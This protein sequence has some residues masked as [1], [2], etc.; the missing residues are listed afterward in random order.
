MTGACRGGLIPRRVLDGRS[1][2]RRMLDEEALNSRRGGLNP[3][4]VLDG[5]PQPRRVL[6]WAVSLKTDARRGGTQFQ[7]GRPQSKRV[8]DRLVLQARRCILNLDDYQAGR[9]QIYRRGGLRST[10]MLDREVFRARRAGLICIRGSFTPHG[11]ATE[12]HFES[13]GKTSKPDGAVSF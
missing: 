10:R 13:D 12:H 1:H 9:Y 8:L 6:D 5:R 7:T 3:R 11:R 4:R 2:L